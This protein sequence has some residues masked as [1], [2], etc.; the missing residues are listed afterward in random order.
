[1]GRSKLAFAEDLPDF[2][3]SFAQNLR[4]PLSRLALILDLQ[5]IVRLPLAEL[6]DEVEQGLEELKSLGLGQ[7]IVAASSMIESTELKRGESRLV[8]RLE[9][10]LWKQ[11]VRRGHEVA[12][13]DYSVVRP[14]FIEPDSNARP[15]AKIRYASE[16][17]W[18]FL[19]GGLFYKEPRQYVELAGK[20][21]SSGMVRA[22]SMSW[23]DRRLLEVA[24]G[25][26]KAGN[27]EQWIAID[28]NIHVVHSIDLVMEAVGAPP[29]VVS[30]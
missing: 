27:P 24:D 28:S 18:L 11:L 12:F 10:A 1:V 30:D 13:G 9:W 14:D 23:G 17:H 8:R 4:V 26:P 25:H 16:D 6:E 19:K 5:S 20:A 3:S 29:V 2:V 7:V 22:N 15:A 21:I